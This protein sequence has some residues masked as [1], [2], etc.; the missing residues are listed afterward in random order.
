MNNYPKI[1]LGY[2]LRW[3][4]LFAIQLELETW[5]IPTF[6]I[7]SNLYQPELRNP[8]AIPLIVVWINLSSSEDSSPR[9]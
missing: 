5:P 9:R 7:K 3:K 1:H 4:L 2:K 8:V 6:F